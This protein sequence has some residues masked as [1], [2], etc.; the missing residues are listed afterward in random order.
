[1]REFS[2][3]S[4]YFVVDGTG[5]YGNGLSGLCDSVERWSVDPTNANASPTW[6]EKAG[7][8]SFTSVEVTDTA[9]YV[10]G[11][12]RWL[13]NPFCGD[14]PCQG[15]IDYRGLG[16]LDPVNGLPLDWNP[17]GVIKLGYYD[18]LPTDKGLFVG[19]D[20][21]VTGNCSCAGL[22]YF[23]LA[24]GH[25]PPA[26]TVATLPVDVYAAGAD[27]VAA[28]RPT[29]ST[30]S[31]LAGPACPRSTT[32]RT[33]PLT[34]S[35]PSWYRPQRQQY[36]RLRHGGQ[37]QSGRCRRRRRVGDLQ[38]VSA[39]TRTTPRWSLVVPGRGRHPRAG[40]A[41]LR[42]PLLRHLAGGSAR[43]QRQR[44]WSGLS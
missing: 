44:G 3:D 30:G 1:M 4:S 42:Q 26:S 39:G 14:T 21:L 15:A 18:F 36:R 23:P 34:D 27:A 31:T 43:L 5:A 9:I 8:D 13:N 28:A 38:P 10:G 41:L 2:P 17:G 11:H 6:V 20:Y 29:S 25:T 19:G 33:G 40:P 37:R 35:D 16:A 22:A 32:V 24:G 12:F 7:G